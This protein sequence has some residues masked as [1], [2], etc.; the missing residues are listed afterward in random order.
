MDEFTREGLAIHAAASLP[1]SQVQAI[2]SGLFA[3]QG[4]PEFLRSDNGPEFIAQALK[5]WLTSQNA[6]T[7]YIDP[8]CP[9]QNG[10]AE[11]FNGRVRDECLNAQAFASVAEAG[12]I[13]EAWRVWYNT[14]RPHSSLNYQTPL[15]F[16][17]AWLVN[18]GNDHRD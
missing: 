6:Q 9:W 8:G 17:Q 5:G 13:T 15:E 14:E 3:R 2:L 18:Q 4:K 1:A 11:S 10:F 7:M 16:K 12:V